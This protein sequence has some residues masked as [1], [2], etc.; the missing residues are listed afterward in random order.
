MPFTSFIYNYYHF[1]DKE[2]SI[3]QL[4]ALTRTARGTVLS[5]QREEPESSDTKYCLATLWEVPRS[6]E[7]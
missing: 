2:I 3:L 6:P 5:Q 7:S 4:A 1:L